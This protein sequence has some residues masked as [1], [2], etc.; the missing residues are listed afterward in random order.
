[1]FQSRVIISLLSA[2]MAQSIFTCLD[3]IMISQKW[4]K[5]SSLA[6]EGKKPTS[7]QERPC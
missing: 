5:V 4:W 1:M 3:K 2:A 7:L 6:S